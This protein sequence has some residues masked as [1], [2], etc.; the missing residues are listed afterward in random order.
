MQIT[1]KYKYQV[2]ETNKQGEG[3]VSNKSI[4]LA[5]QQAKEEIGELYKCEVGEVLITSIVQV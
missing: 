4:E 1:F 2:I 5:I 3:S